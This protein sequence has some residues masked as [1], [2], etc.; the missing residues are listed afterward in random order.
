M[1]GRLT[2]QHLNSTLGDLNAAVTRKYTLLR[3]QPKSTGPTTSAFHHRFLQDET[4]E[5]RGLFFVVEADVK[6]FTR[7]RVDKRFHGILNVLRHC[8][9]VREVR[10]GGLVRYVLC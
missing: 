1:R 8:R 6:E 7:L 4:K 2:L 10:G 9:R 5:T 3:Q